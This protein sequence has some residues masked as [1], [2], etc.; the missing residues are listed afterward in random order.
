[1][2]GKVQRTVDLNGQLNGKVKMRRRPLH[3]HVGA[4]LSP[5]MGANNAEKV[6]PP[7]TGA[8]WMG[9]IQV[10]RRRRFTLKDRCAVDAPARTIF[11][12]HRSAAGN[13]IMGNPPG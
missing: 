3:C 12:I 2:F 1:M 8:T 5:V 6:L 13:L 10:E 9:G 4:G 11:D 7:R